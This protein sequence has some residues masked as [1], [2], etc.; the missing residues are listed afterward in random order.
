MS[1]LSPRGRFGDGP[2]PRVLLVDDHRDV[3]DRVSAT[4]ARDF[5]I[6]GVAGDG[7]QAL[8]T[9]R[10]VDPD[11]IVLDINMPGMDGFQTIEA[12]AEAG[13]RAPVVFLSLIDDV[14]T[15]GE[16][17]RRGGRG[18]VVKSRLSRDLVTAL[19]LVRHGR[20]FVPSLPSLGRLAGG[21]AHAMQ[22]YGDLPGFLDGLAAFF[23]EAL[24]RGDATCVI[25]GA[26]LRQG[27]GDRLLARGWS[28][29]GPSADKRYRAI[30]AADALG[31]FMRNGHPDPGLLATIAAELDQYRVEVTDGGTGRLTIFGTLA[32][33]LSADGNP[34]AAMELERLW[35]SLTHALPF[36]TV[37]GY[38]SA[39]FHDD[40]G[41]WSSA[42]A[43]H[44][45]VSQTQ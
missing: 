24:R 33:S 3:L 18:Y 23:D 10:D 42:C 38:D 25:G 22:I 17:F 21:P 36:F 20:V 6:A 11:L 45:A 8:E 34:T 5:E 2:K 27:L 28:L 40:A 32:G 39:C 15:V 30:D 13:S 12:L 44:W 37:C 9:A 19:D 43:E 35:N 16:A 14:E 41:L 1:R 4:L 26:D 7:R 29:D 31:S